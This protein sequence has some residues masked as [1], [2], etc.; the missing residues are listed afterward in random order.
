MVTINEL[1]DRMLRELDI[2]G[3][4][5]LPKFLKSLVVEAGLTPLEADYY[6]AVLEAKKLIVIDGKGFI[7][8]TE[9]AK[10]AFNKSL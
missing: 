7:F 4:V 2:S 3:I 1:K 5:S 9:E 10:I 6:L 8:R